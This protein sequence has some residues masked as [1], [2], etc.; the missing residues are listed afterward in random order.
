MPPGGL[1]LEL[2]RRA[3]LPRQGHRQ[4]WARRGRRRFR[5]D[6]QMQFVHDA[7]AEQGVVEFAAAFA[8]QSLD[9]PF[10]AQPAERRRKSISF[11]PQIFTSSADARSLSSRAAGARRVVRMMIGENL[12]WKTSAL[13]FMVPEPLTMTRRLYSASPRPSAGGGTSPDRVRGDGVQIHRARAGHHGVRRR[14]QF[15]QCARSRRLL[16]EET[17]AVG[18]GDLAVRRHRH[19]DENEGRGVRVESDFALN[20]FHRISIASP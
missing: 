15:E 1:E 17:R 7:G 18:G 8:Q 20:G 6:G 12:R 5:T 9:A 13:G 4:S 10:C 11:A 19:V 2:R 16:K 14:P 3:S